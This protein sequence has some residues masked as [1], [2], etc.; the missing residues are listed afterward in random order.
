MAYI[1]DY[2]DCAGNT[3]KKIRVPS[4]QGGSDRRVYVNGNDSGYYLGNNNDRVYKGGS[5]V[6]KDL[7]SFAKNRLWKTFKNQR[8]MLVFSFW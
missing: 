3:R 1:D 5:E 2:Y 8:I 7:V 4:E 6:A